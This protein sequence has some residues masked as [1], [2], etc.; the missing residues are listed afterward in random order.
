MTKHKKRK[1]TANEWNAKHEVGTAV[2]YWP[3]LP[4]H[5]SAPPV[6]TT[7]RSRAWELGDGTAVVSIV[8]R[9]G[10]VHLEHLELLMQKAEDTN[11]TNQAK[12]TCHSCEVLPQLHAQVAQ[13]CKYLGIDP[14]A[15]PADSRAL[16]DA[17]VKLKGEHERRR[18]RLVELEMQLVCERTANAEFDKALVWAGG[19]ALLRVDHWSFA[20]YVESFV[21]GDPASSKAALVRLYKRMK[22]G[23]D[24]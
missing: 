10:G 4:P 3:V 18:N 9:C 21:P 19:A 12:C 22:R 24:G 16:R 8:G 6:D 17:I 2:R 15:L 23:T 5:P 11:M 20:N 14:A 7:T 13:L 1:L